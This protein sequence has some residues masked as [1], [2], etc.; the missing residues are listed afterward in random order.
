MKQMPLI[1]LLIIVFLR[2]NLTFSKV[3]HLILASFCLGTNCTLRTV[4]ILITRVIDLRCLKNRLQKYF[5]DKLIVHQTKAAN[6]PDL[7]YYSQV[8]LQT[9]INKLAYL[10]KETKLEAIKHDLELPQEDSD[11]SNLFYTAL[12]PRMQ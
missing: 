1:Q 7:I 10:K 12:P 4:T 2:L 5:Q 11:I 9:A 3:S 6:E 8:N